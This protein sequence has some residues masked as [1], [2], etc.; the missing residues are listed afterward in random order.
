MSIFELYRQ[1]D[2]FWHALSPNLPGSGAS[3]DQLC[4]IGFPHSKVSF[5]QDG[6]LIAAVANLG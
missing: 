1:V 6:D 4:C 3:V 2:D 5:A